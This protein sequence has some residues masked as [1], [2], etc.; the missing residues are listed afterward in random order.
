MTDSLSNPVEAF[1]NR[2][3]AEFCIIVQVPPELWTDHNELRPINFRIQ[4]KFYLHFLPA[5]ALKVSSDGGFTE[6]NH[7]Y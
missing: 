4:L 3:L 7:F 1:S 5:I 6:A 2:R